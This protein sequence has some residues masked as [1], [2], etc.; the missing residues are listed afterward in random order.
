MLGWIAALEAVLRDDAKWDGCQFHRRAYNDQAHFDVPT[1][2]DIVNRNRGPVIVIQK[3]QPKVLVRFTNVMQRRVSIYPITPRNEIDIWNAC[4]VAFQAYQDGEPRIPSRELI[5]YLILRKLER[6][7]KWGG[8]ALNKAFLWASDL[9]KGGFPKEVLDKR[10][11]L[12]VAH[13]LHGRG[14]LDRK[15]SENE[16]KYAL[17][18]KPVVQPI[19]DSREFAG[20]PQ[21]QT[22][23]NNSPSLVSAKLLDFNET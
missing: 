23:F 8:G 11:I 7:D 13:T 2:A 18:P 9:P 5:A 20:W 19:L 22:Y 17:G 12:D 14:L 10:D 6:Q 21:L 15:Q 16:W 1:A 4:E 3:V